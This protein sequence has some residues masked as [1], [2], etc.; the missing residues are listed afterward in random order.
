MELYPN[1]GLI[2]AF[3]EMIER[4]KTLMNFER[5]RVFVSPVFEIESNMRVPETKV[6]LV[7]ML[8]N[9][10]A[11]PFHRK[12]CRLCHTIPKYDKWMM[13]P[14]ASKLKLAI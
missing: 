10:T 1:P 8:R 2:P 3:L 4:N 5:P 14:V 7:Q 12:I 9:N 11:I 13:A 6:E